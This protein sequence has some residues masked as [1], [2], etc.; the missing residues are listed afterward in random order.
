[1]RVCVFGGGA[2]GGHLAARLANGGGGEGGGPATVSVVARGPQLAALRERGL[3]VL[4][5]GGEL[6]ARVRASD[7]PA[8]L[9]QQDAVLVTVK[10]PALPSVAAAIAP[11]LGPDTAVAFVM[12]GIPWWYFDDEGGPHAGTPLPQLDPRGALRTA[13]GRGRT[14]GGV[15]YSACTVVEPGVVHVSSPASRVVLGEPDGAASP[16]AERLAAALQGDAFTA[17]VTGRI[18][19]AV[20]SKLLLN[21]PTAALGVPAGTGMGP[22]LDEPAL[23]E[24]ANRV[25]AEGLAIARALGCTP[26]IDESRRQQNRGNGHV[27][28]IVQDLQLGRPMEV[29]AQLGVPLALARLA[30]VETP[31]LDL[32]VALSRVRAR[33]AGLY[34]GPAGA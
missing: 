3:R 7:D 10:A 11:L 16:R 14:I 13:L 29:E 24:A 32:L 21:L 31:T 9:G 17:S 19:D 30:G 33:A 6:H 4:T 2:I 15:V 8:E 26:Q 20:W 34:D 23:E 18:R 25:T 27:P 12:N 28:S 1:M 22:V 5:P